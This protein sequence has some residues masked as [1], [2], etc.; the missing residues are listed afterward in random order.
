[1]QCSGAQTCKNPPQ[2]KATAAV[3]VGLHA[4]SEDPQ[5]KGSNIINSMSICKESDDDMEDILGH[6]EEEE[7]VI[8]ALEVLES[9]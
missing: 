2:S 1:M 7:H 9:E 4:L 5:R 8:T 6:G 3:I